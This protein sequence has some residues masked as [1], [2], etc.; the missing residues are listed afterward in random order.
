MSR[1]RSPE[2]RRTRRIIRQYL[3]AALVANSDD[4]TSETRAAAQRVVD[5]LDAKL[6]AV[7]A[8][9]TTQK[10]AP[11]PAT[12]TAKATKKAPTPAADVQLLSLDE[13][14]SGKRPTPAVARQRVRQHQAA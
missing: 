12:K 9:Q 6:T 5:R 13:L 7:L 1:S 11:A 2:S 14:A 10:A 8:V 4:E 3:R